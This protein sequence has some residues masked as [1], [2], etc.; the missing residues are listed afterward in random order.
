MRVDMRIER[1]IGYRGSELQHESK[2]REIGEILM[3]SLFSPVK[4][5]NY[6][7][8]D[9]RV[10]RATDHN[11][12]TIEVWTDGTIG[13]LDAVTDA[14][15]RLIEELQRIATVSVGDEPPAEVEPVVLTQTPLGELVS[16]LSTRIMNTIKRS[17]QVQFVEDLIELRGAD[18]LESL[19]G[20]G[21]K[22]AADIETALDSLSAATEE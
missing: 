5:V 10:G 8:D 20:I 18:R 9:V 4:A 15:E 1:G 16:V 6:Q 14:A 11:R 19:S 3:D 17:G 13:P 7:V 2:E 12:L 22:A 21:E